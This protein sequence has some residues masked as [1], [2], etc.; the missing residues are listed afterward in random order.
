MSENYLAMWKDLGL[1]LNAHDMLLDVR[2][3]YGGSQ[4]EA[5]LD[6]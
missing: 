5:S 3:H 6:H 4:L 2:M 1:N